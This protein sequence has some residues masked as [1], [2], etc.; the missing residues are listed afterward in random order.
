[1]STSKHDIIA[2][3]NDG[4][5]AAGGGPGGGVDND[6][7]V[8]LFTVD[9]THLASDTS[10][11][12]NPLA[13][14]VGGELSHDPAPPA[15]FGCV[16]KL[17]MWLA[18]QYNPFRVSF[19]MESLRGEV[20]AFPDFPGYFLDFDSEITGL[21]SIDDTVAVFTERETYL[22]TGDGPDR[23]GNGSFQ[24]RPIGVGVGCSDWRSV[25]SSPIGIFFAGNQ[26]IWLL[27][28]GIAAPVNIGS[29]I[30]ETLRQYPVVISAVLADYGDQQLMHFLL[31][32]T[33]DYT[34]GAVQVEGEAIQ[35]D[36]DDYIQ[37]SE[38]ES[39]HMVYSLGTQQWYRWANDDYAPLVAGL[40]RRP[41]DD[42]GTEQLVY[43]SALTGAGETVTTRE[44]QFWQPFDIVGDDSELP[45]VE[46]QTHQWHPWGLTG[47]AA[48]DRVWWRVRVDEE[49]PA[50]SLTEV[51]VGESHSPLT[52]TPAVR[53]GWQN[54]EFRMP[55]SRVPELGLTLSARSAAFAGLTYEVTAEGFAKERTAQ[56]TG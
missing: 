7:G 10:I 16:G 15:R 45:S 29:M 19:S 3:P 41:Q 25:A 13:Y 5:G 21:A 52:I 22:V 48:V 43:A 27:P 55:W 14:T 11:K 33:G 24:V 44:E 17:R 51:S 31:K 53:A 39:R 30:T 1:M 35:I 42:N 50:W 9:T 47:D 2:G 49:Q 32:T 26:T 36:G 6:F 34:G 54:V 38:S 12:D 40:M 28:R 56:R 8:R 20:P 18:G 4:G 46:I 23:I 37:I